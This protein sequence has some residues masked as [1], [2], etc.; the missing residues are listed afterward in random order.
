MAGWNQKAVG[1]PENWDIIDHSEYRR[2]RPQPPQDLPSYTRRPG[3]AAGMDEGELRRNFSGPDAV[4]PDNIPI[5]RDMGL[6]FRTNLA[7]PL[8]RDYAVS[9]WLTPLR[10]SQNPIMFHGEPSQESQDSGW[11]SVDELRQLRRRELESS[12]VPPSRE[13]DEL[14]FSMQHQ[15]T[16]EEPP[17]KNSVLDNVLLTTFLASEYLISHPFRVL[18]RQCQVNA[19]CNRC[20]IHPLALIPSM[21]RLTR[22]QGF[23][24]LWKGLPGTLVIRGM[25]YWTE[26]ILSK[27][28]PW[29][30]EWPSR[31]SVGKAVQHIFL[32]GTSIVLQMPFYSASLVE[33]VQSD[34]AS[35]PPGIFDVIQE[36]IRRALP[37]HHHAHSARLINIWSLVPLSLVH[38]LSFYCI[39]SIVSRVMA[40]AIQWTSRDHTSRVYMKCRADFW[41]ACLAS[42]IS[43]PL[44]TIYHRLLLQGTRTIVDNLERGTE[45]VPILSRYEGVRD[46]IDGIRIDE[47]YLGFYKGFGALILDF[48]LRY[49]LLHFTHFLALRLLPCDEDLHAR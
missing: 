4:R 7:M 2:S 28:T 5:A 12:S 43:F 49:A 32:K 46:C 30:K 6:N 27:I 25:S 16:Y 22:W 48:S 3:S 17:E 35:D 21:V 26:D 10:D 1:F 13:A 8:E 40:R 42:V 19:A 15:R 41:G 33:T 18:R 9:D 37:G 23:G 11:V 39:S 24:C 29:P 47:G 34:I 31:P 36:G 20:H 14:R 38:G 44:E 45:V